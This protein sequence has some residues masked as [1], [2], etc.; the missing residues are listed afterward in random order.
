MLPKDFA[1]HDQ[2]LWIFCINPKPKINLSAMLNIGGKVDVG[3]MG[4]V[5][6]VANVALASTNCLFIIHWLD[7]HHLLHPLY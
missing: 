4:S 1:H 6:P 7:F 3:T 2:A 5:S